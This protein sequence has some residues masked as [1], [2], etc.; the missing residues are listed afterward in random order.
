MGSILSV[1]SRW[2]VRLGS[3]DSVGPGMYENVVPSNGPVV[4]ELGCGRSAMSGASQVDADHHRHS[5]GART[6]A[7]LLVIPDVTH[8]WPPRSA[9]ARRTPATSSS[10]AG[11]GETR[12]GT[13]GRPTD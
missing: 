4:F 11:N 2:S 7:R 6:C 1:H 5:T 9:P 10:V 13:P 8:R 12:S 3:I